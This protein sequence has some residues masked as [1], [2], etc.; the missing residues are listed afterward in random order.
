M[1]TGFNCPDLADDLHE[2]NTSR[3]IRLCMDYGRLVGSATL[4][5][6]LKQ[7]AATLVGKEASLPISMSPSMGSYY[8]AAAN[9]RD[10]EC[11]IVVGPNA[12][13]DADNLFRKRPS[14]LVAAASSRVRP[15]LLARPPGVYL[16]SG[17]D[18]AG[19]FSVEQAA[20]NMPV[21]LQVGIPAEPNLGTLP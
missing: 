7:L 19:P 2:S 8:L 6:K 20:Q 18:V 21:F 14:R 4:G 9:V 3:T 16:V 17:A 13:R 12:K 1:P 15:E 10:P 5:Q 11:A